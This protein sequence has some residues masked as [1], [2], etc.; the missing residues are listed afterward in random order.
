MP[1]TNIPPIGPRVSSK[2]WSL[3]NTIT[4]TTGMSMCAKKD[5]ASAP[6]VSSSRSRMVS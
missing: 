1:V 6:C 3:L 2:S 4:S 5:E